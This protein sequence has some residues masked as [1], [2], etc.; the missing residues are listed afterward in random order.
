MQN[1]S[2]NF[3]KSIQTCLWTEGA[4]NKWRRLADAQLQYVRERSD[5]KLHGMRTLC[6]QLLV[7]W[8][9]PASTFQPIK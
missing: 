6:V 1:D 7:R 4:E 2:L 8:F 3:M 5:T 9:P